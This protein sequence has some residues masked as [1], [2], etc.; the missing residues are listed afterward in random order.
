[1]W[2]SIVKLMSSNL[3]YVFLGV[4][5]NFLLPKFLSTDAYALQ[6][7]FLFFLSYASLLSLGYIDGT[8]VE[9]GGKSVDVTIGEK[10]SARTTFFVL[11][12][13]I[14]AAAVAGIGI[15]VCNAMIVTCAAGL[16]FL[17]ILNYYKNLCVAVGEYDLFSFSVCFEKTASCVLFCVLIFLFRSNDYIWYCMVYIIVWMLS[18]VYFGRSYKNKLRVPYYVRPCLKDGVHMMGVGF[19][20]MIGNLSYSLLSGLDRWFVKIYMENYQFAM[21][22]FAISLEQI[23]NAFLT[24]IGNVL[25]NRI[26]RNGDASKIREYKRMIYVWSYLVIAAAFG[27]KFVIMHF[28]SGYCDSLDIIFVLFLSQITNIMISAIYINIYRS[29]QNSKEMIYEV[30]GMLAVGSVLN[31]IGYAIWPGMLSFAV[32]TLI[33]R[34]IWLSVC[35]LKRRD[36]FA[37]MSAVI[38]VLILSATFIITGRLNNSILGLGGYL[39]VFAV[40]TILLMRNTI[41]PVVK[42]V[43][44]HLGIR[45]QKK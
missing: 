15:A 20:F 44:E 36:T 41:N 3:I 35:I 22:S 9:Y 42:L 23:I 40:A 31:Y 21:Y 12:Q 14:V 18:C 13:I 25:Y 29:N 28:L 30:V 34:Y 37:G 43:Q 17:N 4:I 27:A 16:F 10:L 26:C 45:V 5:I 7:E 8:F 2:K 1:M 24:P 38:Y 32:A 39:L 19:P 33:V 11:F 6:K